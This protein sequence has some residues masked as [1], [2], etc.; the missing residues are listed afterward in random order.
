MSLISWLSGKI[1][2]TFGYL[3]FVRHG[4]YGQ[5]LPIRTAVPIVIGAKVNLTLPG[6]KEGE[7]S[8]HAGY[9]VDE[10]EFVESSDL[11]RELYE[12]GIH[13]PELVRKKSGIPVLLAIIS[14]QR[15]YYFARTRDSGG[16]YGMTKL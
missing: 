12:F 11:V 9:R 2:P 1:T 6:E 10:V 5:C 3:Y 15:L 16:S 8:R 13:R 14:G 7:C 4:P